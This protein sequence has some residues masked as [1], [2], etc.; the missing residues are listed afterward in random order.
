MNGSTCDAAGEATKCGVRAN[1]G[2]YRGAKALQR[3]SFG[4]RDS[5]EMFQQRWAVRP[6]HA[7]AAVDNGVTLQRADRHALHAGNSPLSRKRLE[8]V[9]Q[10]VEGSFAILRQVHPAAS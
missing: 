7:P 10:L 3:L 1:H 6:R 8:S 2:L 4:K 5:F 9:L